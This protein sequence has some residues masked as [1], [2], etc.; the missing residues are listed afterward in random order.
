MKKFQAEQ[1][2]KTTRGLVFVLMEL[3]QENVVMVV[4]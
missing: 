4:Y 3:T 1:V 2:Q